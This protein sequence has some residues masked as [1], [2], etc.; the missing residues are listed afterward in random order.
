MPDSNQPCPEAEALEIPSYL[1]EMISDEAEAAAELI[2]M[3]LDDAASS[4]EKLDRALAEN[5]PDRVTRLLHSMKGSCGQMGALKISQLC[6]GL[7][8]GA[9]TG[10]LSGARL[11]FP[12]MRSAFSEV[13][14]LMEGL[15]PQP[16]K[17]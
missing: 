12:E 13:R 6:A 1:A 8:S 4:L 14:H 11:R 10:D 16:V 9:L 2:Q 7:E 17:L 15:L 5:S 3:F